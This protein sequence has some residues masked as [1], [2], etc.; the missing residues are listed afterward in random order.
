VKKTFVIL[1][2]FIFIIS[3]K[4]KSGDKL[5]N[6]NGKIIKLDFVTPKDSLFNGYGGE[7]YEN[8]A[9]KSLTFF[10]NGKIIDTLV[11]YY[12]NGN[13]KKKGL[14]ENNMEYGWWSYNHENG[15]LNKKIEWFQLRDSIYKNQEIYFDVNEDIRIAP[16][17]YFVLQIPDTIQIGKNIA[18]INNYISNANDF[19]VRYLKVII[20]NRYSDTEKRIDTFTNGSSSPFFGIYADKIG[21]KIVEGMIEEKT[22]K[23]DT[24]NMDSLSL[25]IV[26][27]Y[28]YFKKEVYVSDNGKKSEL[29]IKLR[30]E[31]EKMNENN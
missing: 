25:T 20:E 1:L 12:E 9:L 18:H 11:Y 26:D 2:S 29:S 13:V 5:Y 22:I 15:K 19:D 27:Q 16:S 21:W 10:E 8:G 28:R 4:E 23:T 14:V 7:H 24:I 17:T 3:C 31:F 6:Y 30:S